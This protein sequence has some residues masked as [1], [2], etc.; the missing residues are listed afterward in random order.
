MVKPLLALTRV[1]CGYSGRAVLNEVS[2][3]IAQGELVGVIGPNGSGKTTFA[4]LIAGILPPLSGA[5]LYKGQPPG[6]IGASRFARE[7]AFLPSDIELFAPATVEEVVALARFP[8]TGVFRR[9]SQ[10]D[11]AAVAHA[12]ERTGMTPYATRQ[13]NE[14]S[15]GE[16]QRALL[17][18]ALA[19]EPQM[20]ILDEP[21]SHLDIGHQTAVMDLLSEMN[22]AG[23]TIVAI[24][25]DLNLAAEYCQ[26]LLL[27]EDG[28]LVADGA[29]SEVLTFSTIE[30]VYRTAVLVY[31]NPH[32][33]RPHIFAIPGRLARTHGG[34]AKRTP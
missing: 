32:T 23:T 15:E 7:V 2:C 5:V 33:G 22:A 17:A 20:L 31:P 25:H 14:L 11:K 27:F 28:R 34:G 13:L 3:T 1:C 4:R 6:S 9:F 18:Q 19:Q 8:F 21:T 24:L 26:R 10:E 30:Q 29:P 16:R 12:L